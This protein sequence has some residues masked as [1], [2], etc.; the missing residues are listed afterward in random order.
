MNLPEFAAKLQNG[1]V[2]LRSTAVAVPLAIPGSSTRQCPGGPP[3]PWDDPGFL[4]AP[5]DET[6]RQPGPPVPAR[7]VSTRPAIPDGAGYPGPPTK[8]NGGQWV[9][10]RSVTANAKPSIMAL[11]S[12]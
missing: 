12:V 9:L 6:P 2:R 3:G 4:E 10:K 5:Q 7:P 8:F 11:L 1:E